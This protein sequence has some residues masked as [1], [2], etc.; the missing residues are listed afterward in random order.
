MVHLQQPCNNAAKQGGVTTL[1]EKCPDG[2]SPCLIGGQSCCEG[3]F[4]QGGLC[5]GA[6][7]QVKG[8]VRK[9]N[10]GAAQQKK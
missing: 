5:Q 6:A 1:G 4:G 8:N 10:K 3:Q 7:K 2:C 9:G